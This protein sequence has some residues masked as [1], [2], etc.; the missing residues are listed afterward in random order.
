M[1]S[2]LAKVALTITPPNDVPVIAAILAQSVE[3]ERTLTF[4]VIVARVSSGLLGGAKRFRV[5][6][7]DPFAVCRLQ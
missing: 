2:N 5:E 4:S 6:E 7:F 1:L 3:Q